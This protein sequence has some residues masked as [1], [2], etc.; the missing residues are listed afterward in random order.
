MSSGLNHMR[1]IRETQTGGLPNL[2]GLEVTIPRMCRKG[3]KQF[4]IS[5][6]T[7]VDISISMKNTEQANGNEEKSRKRK[8]F[9]ICTTQRKEDPI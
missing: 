5:S 2:Y 3:P 7:M 6:L 1:E 9:L 4:L 8:Q